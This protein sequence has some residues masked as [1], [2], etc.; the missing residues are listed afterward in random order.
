VPGAVVYVIPVERGRTND[1]KRT[2]ADQ[3]GHY[4]L[5]GITP[6]NYQVFSWDWIENGAHYDPDFLK[7][8]EQQAKVVVVR[9]SSNQN[10][11]LRLIPVP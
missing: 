1:Y 7:Q 8:Y 6:G 10:V 11:D 5:V 4:S 9:E 2:A 3:N